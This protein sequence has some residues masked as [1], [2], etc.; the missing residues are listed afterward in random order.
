MAKGHPALE[1]QQERKYSLPQS[2]RECVEGRQHG[3]GYT[4]LGF[5]LLKKADVREQGTLHFTEGLSF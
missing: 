4:H 1:S 2:S 5:S 3:K